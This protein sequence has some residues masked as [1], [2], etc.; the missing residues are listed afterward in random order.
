[1][2][3]TRYYVAR[4]HVCRLQ[5]GYFSAIE[6]VACLV[7]SF[8]AAVWENF[9]CF[10]AVGLV[11]LKNVWQWSWEEMQQ[12]VKD[13]QVLHRLY[14]NVSLIAWSIL[15]IWC[16]SVLAIDD[17]EKAFDLKEMVFA[18]KNW[19][20][21]QNKIWAL[22]MSNHYDQ[23]EK[24]DLRAKVDRLREQNHQLT[25]LYYDLWVASESSSNWDRN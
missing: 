10:C 22:S 5:P 24:R 16:P 8:L 20:A 15:G 7:F 14:V 2:V 17:E 21:A 12:Y 23:R 19:Q 25:M 9:F 11:L 1:M 6:S 4:A 3:Y 13:C 18:H